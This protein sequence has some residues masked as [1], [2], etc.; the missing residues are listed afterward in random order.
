MLLH[1]VPEALFSYFFLPLLPMPSPFRFSLF[2]IL[3]SFLLA[4]TM[5]KERKR[6]RAGRARAFVN[7]REPAT[8][9]RCPE[10]MEG[11]QHGGAWAQ[12]DPDTVRSDG[13]DR[14]AGANPHSSFP[15]GRARETPAGPAVFRSTA[16]FTGPFARSTARA[17]RRPRP[18]ECGRSMGKE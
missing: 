13:V 14:P 3:V 17:R 15:R 7:A 5:K 1:F 6:K 8:E 18:S 12:A 4:V 2:W 10:S 11:A 16:A 9:H